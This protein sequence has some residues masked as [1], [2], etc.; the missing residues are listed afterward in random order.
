MSLSGR[1]IPVYLTAGG[2]DMK[3]RSTGFKIGMLVCALAV[4]VAY[5]GCGG[6]PAP[7]PSDS[8][9]TGIV[10]GL[11]SAP[12][13]LDPRLGTDVSSARVQQLLY[14]SLVKKT[15]DS[16]LVGDLA[17]KW[18][19]VNNRTYRFFLKKNV[20]FHNGETLTAYDVKA[21]FDSILNDALASPKKSAY[22]KL[23]SIT[24]EDEYTI[25]FQ[26]R[27]PFA[28]F[29]INMVMGILPRSEI[30][31]PDDGHGILPI[32]T[33]PFRFES[34][35]GDDEIRLARFDSYFEGTP[36]LTGI[37][38]RIIPD[39]TIRT[40]ELEKGDLDFLQNNVPIDSLERLNRIETLKVMTGPGT[41]YYYIGFNFRMDTPLR[42]VRVR[43]ALAMALNRDSMIEHLLGGLA[44]KAAGVIPRGH[45][46]FN[47]DIEQI[48]YDPEGARA[49]L[50]EAGLAAGDDGVRLR[51]KFKCPQN[52]QSQR[53]A[54]VIQAQWAEAGVQMDIQS[55]E[56][57]TFYDDIVKGNFETYVLSWVGVTDPDILF[58]IY[59]SDNVPPNGRNRGWFKS[60]PLDRLLIEG[61]TELDTG[62]RASI[63]RDAQRLIAEEL[64]CI[65]LWHTHNIA[66]MKRNIAG[67]ELYPAGDFDSFAKV[68]REIRKE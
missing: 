66:V 2:S 25:V 12:Q 26:T 7:V 27:E 18:E 1:P 3:K 13:S 44:S 11:G 6:R 8:T 48:P 40:M 31:K 16:N 43:R 58:S 14:N 68:S 24:V 65:S 21:T 15:I 55:L 63:Y 52:K 54:E 38:F 37:R 9:D 50:G 51:I 35:E 46:A 28:P 4:C 45:W 56:W 29:L 10:I 64:P 32:G 49:L 60:E 47:P 36:G 22:E 19:I 17:E 20:Q 33:G 41:S 67:Y 59:H 42:D 53:L 30:E 62:A 61:R 5:W 39:D 34:R 57:G 23:S